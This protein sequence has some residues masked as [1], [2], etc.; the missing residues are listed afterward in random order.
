MRRLALSLPLLLVVAC[1]KGELS[2]PCEEDKDCERDLQC[3]G[4][5]F[6]PGIE[7]FQCSAYCANDAEC[8]GGVCYA[9][10]FCARE[11]DA[12]SPDCPDG[13]VCA[14]LGDGALS[15]CVLPCSSDEDCSGSGLPFCPT[16]GGACSDVK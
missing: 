7:G 9:S 11:C 10:T 3:Q 8:D 1:G 13:T 16:P 6:S 15:Y 5:T 2:A 12:T 14:G 4:R